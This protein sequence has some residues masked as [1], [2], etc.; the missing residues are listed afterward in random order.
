MFCFFGAYYHSDGFQAH[1]ES[2]WC[3]RLKGRAMNLPTRVLAEIRPLISEGFFKFVFAICHHFKI[4]SQLS[5]I[6]AIH[7][8]MCV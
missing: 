4:E 1:W 7:A 8:L 6:L 5:L 2:F 3:C